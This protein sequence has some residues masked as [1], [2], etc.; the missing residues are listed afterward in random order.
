[1][2]T[3]HID[4]LAGPFHNCLPDLYNEH[5]HHSMYLY[6]VSQHYCHGHLGS[7]LEGGI[8]PEVAFAMRSWPLLLPTL[9]FSLSFFFF[10]YIFCFW[11]TLEKLP[12]LKMCFLQYFGI[13]RR[14]GNF[15]FFWYSFLVCPNIILGGGG[16]ISSSGV[17]PK[18]VK[19]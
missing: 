17:S 13:T 12:R 18:W 4:I 1:M 5:L 6:R 10:F 11:P 15:Y 7:V 14:Y 9:L 19:S 2:V 16:G 3:G 8:W